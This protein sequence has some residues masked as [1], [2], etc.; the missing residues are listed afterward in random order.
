MDFTVNQMDIK[1]GKKGAAGGLSNFQPRPFVID[2][3]EC[4]SM[5]GFLQS[6]KFKNIDMQRHIC[7]LTGYA[8]K[9]S[10]KGKNWQKTQT[11]WWNG[12]PIKR[13]S[14]EYQELLD[15]AFVALFKN[16]KARACLLSTGD[17]TLTHSIGWH[18]I[19]DTVLTRNEFCSRLMNIR[20][21]VREREL[22][23]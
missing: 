11:L 23:E 1:S 3:V 21:I 5:E 10:G 8:A 20:A 12:Q 9:K 4:A 16:K 7:T 19:N 2:G 15:R 22:I 18:K 13:D 6:L 17:A 14:D